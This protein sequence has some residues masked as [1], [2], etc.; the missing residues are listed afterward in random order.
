MKKIFLFAAAA[1]AAMTVNATVYNFA[2]V[3]AD[4]ITTDG[5]LGTYVMDEVEIPSVSQPDGVDINVKIAGLDNLVINYTQSAGKSKDNILK[6]AANYMQADGKNVIL[7]FSN[8]TPGDAIALVVAAKG[9]TNAKFT[10]LSGAVGSEQEVAKIDKVEDYVTVT[11]TA[12]PDVVEIKETSGGYRI[13]SATVG[14][15]QGVDNVFEDAK[16]VKTFENGQL[17]IIK[18][19]VRYNALGVQ[20]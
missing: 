8:V 15:S 4:K 6:F 14:A 3:T 19:G 20:F 1:V 10:A 5:T 7:T 17:V 11:F 2:G 9:S 16:A 13:V 12:I 18:N